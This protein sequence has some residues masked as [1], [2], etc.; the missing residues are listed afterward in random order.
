[1]DKLPS[2]CFHKLD[3]ETRAALVTLISETRTP[4]AQLLCGGD[5]AP[6]SDPGQTLPTSLPKPTSARGS[7][8]LSGLPLS[9]PP[10]SANRGTAIRL[11][12][13]PRRLRRL[14]ATQTLAFDPPFFPTVLKKRPV[15]PPRTPEGAFQA[16]LLSA[17][18]QKRW[19]EVLAHARCTDNALAS[20]SAGALRRARQCLRGCA[21]TVLPTVISSAVRTQLRVNPAAQTASDPQPCGAAASR[22]R[23]TLKG[24]N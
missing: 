9:P 20:P 6:T 13:I 1:M 11:S 12:E 19:G 10:S 24:E 22:T 4:A 21:P 17:L 3:V 15:W 8:L 7:T 14:T 5:S 23:L 16:A 2:P 18:N